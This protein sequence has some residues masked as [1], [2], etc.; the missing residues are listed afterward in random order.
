MVEH[1]TASRPPTVK[2]TALLQSEPV[3]ARRAALILAAGAS[4]RM[5]TPKALLAWQGTTLL[6]YVLAQARASAIDE[7]V[8]VLGTATRH[9]N[10]SLGDVRIVFN[11]EPASGRSTSIRIGSEAVPEDVQAVIIQSVDQPCPVD[12]L[13]ALFSAVE[14]QVGEIAVP[15]FEGRRG[16]PVCFG[17]SLLPELRTV[18]E[19]EEGLR[20]VVRR[21]AQHLVEVPVRSPAVL[22]NLND[23]A[24]YAAAQAHVVQP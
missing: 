20:A 19:E 13:N 10:G 15:T 8:V 2:A 9:L 7:V 4:Q 21:H 3:A 22:W 24:A 11:L 6:E 1:S 17:G 5:G 23:P 16:H 14:Q 12:V 18:T